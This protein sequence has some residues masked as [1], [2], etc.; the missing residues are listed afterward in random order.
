MLGTAA[1]LVWS[2]IGAVGQ[3][4]ISPGRD[5]ALEIVRFGEITKSDADGKDYGV[6]WE[7]LREVHRV[8]VTF[9][10][11]PSHAP[12]LQYWRSTWPEK[13]IPRDDA[14]GSGQSGWLNTGDWL[15]G[16]WQTA[17]TNVAANGAT[18]TYSF[19]PLTRKEFPKLK[20]FDVDFRT[21]FK[22]R[23]VDAEPLKEIRSFEVY[24]D[25]VVK[26]MEVEIFWGG[27]ATGPETWDGRLEIFNG[28]LESAQPLTPASKV[29]M[30]GDAS[31]NSEVQGALDGVRARL[32]YAE[33]QHHN[34]FDETVVTV[35]T[36]RETFSFLPKDLLQWGHIVLPEYGAIVRLAGSDMT[37]AAAV[38]ACSESKDKDLYNRV[39]D[40]PEQ[41]FP[42]AWGDVPA[43]GRH[44]IPLSFEG[45]RQHFRLNEEGNIAC[46]KNWIARLPGK[47]TPRCL[48]ADNELAYHFG[49]P[50]SSMTDRQIVDGCKPM[51]VMVW[52]HDGVRYT[53]TAF[54]APLAGVPAPGGRILAD[55]TLVMLIRFEME[56]LPG[57]SAA[58]ARLV[59]STTDGDAEEK[60]K[61]SG[62]RICV[63]S[64][65]GLR[66][67][68]SD[69]DGVA[70]DGGSAVYTRKL[71]PAKAVLDIAI[72]YI[73]LKPEDGAEL[74]QLEALKFDDAFA[75]VRA[76]WQARIDAGTQ[77]RTP[78]T[79]INEFYKADVSHLMI[80]CEREV[81][82]SD[83]YMAKVGTFY[84][85]AYANESCM[86]V[87]DLDRRGYNERAAQVIESWLH[88]QGKRPLPGDYS[89]AEGEFYS[90]GGYEDDNGYN[91]HHG[92][93]LWCI[94]EHY[95][96]T[97]D[98]AWM[99]HAAPNIVK[100]CDW[101]INERRRTIEEAAKSPI[102]AI[103]RG[104]LPPGSLEDIGDWRSW[105]SNNVF[106]WWGMDN[107]ARALAAAGHPEG[108]RLLR[109]ANAYK[110]DIWTAFGEAMRRS[111]VVRLRDGSWIPHIPSDAHRRGRSFGWITETLEGAIY[112][113]RTG[114]LDAS[115][116]EAGWIIRDFEDNLY[117]S[118]QYGY[119]IKGDD[120][121]KYWFSR[122]GISQQANLLGNPVPYL[123]R[124]EIPHYLR[125]YF[126]AFAVS[127][128][129]DTRMMTEHALPNIGDFRGDHYKSSDES[130][131]T[132]WLRL[133][134]IAERGED[135]Y[136]GQAVPRYWLADGQEIGIE[137]A[138]TY[139]GP[140][141]MKMSSHAAEGKIVMTI[142]PPK[143][144]PPKR[145][146]ARFRHP[147]NARIL[148]CEVNG[149]AY[150]KFDAEKEWVELSGL[151]GHTEIV[152]FFK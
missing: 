35:R 98:A 113:V 64:D 107:A 19:A 145:I 12:E 149:A 27:N 100:A 6:M 103:E 126:N 75:A 22:V 42:H 131:S 119:D 51:A 129:P 5:S 128:F 72:P 47:D 109:E 84:Y 81:T 146:F 10:A 53:E 44:Y 95:W 93:V 70:M 88:Y 104:L 89:T 135:L 38:K 66:F 60:L 108:D 50:A 28:V 124:D 79:M 30:T 9:A 18:F 43:K 8:V 74:A 65:Q 144:N 40:M 112:L 152:A 148:R 116:R 36:S 96:Y 49:L 32:S 68:I 134:Y 7:D 37:Y 2:A 15:Q 80:N 21:T 45:S 137:N 54:A 1:I 29:R 63:A 41:T 86:M 97:R 121:E 150:D 13:R 59:F 117:I 46:I 123:L 73:T 139:F 25:S 120:F 92:W 57:A 85:G 102:R 23:L 56:P 110:E 130:N 48:W 114:L 67:R 140:M 62:H 4:A 33:T 76:Y 11:P 132:Y 101:I 138:Q 20:D 151:G 94:G 78:E 55:D 125:A 58:E 141:S 127:F 99:E 115:S 143:R 106:S 83:C 147:E 77:I 61:Q 105:L 69:A 136:L 111:P 31:W 118:E 26:P 90:A 14:S 142:E 71:G 16:K 91:Q 24:T 122:G 34:S 3:E 87:T 39:F 133:M 82:G 52:E 17:D